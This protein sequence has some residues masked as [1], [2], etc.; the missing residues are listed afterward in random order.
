[1]RRFGRIF[2]QTP[3]PEAAKVVDLTGSNPVSRSRPY[4]FP[5]TTDPPSELCAPAV[6]ASRRQ[7]LSTR[8]LRNSSSSLAV[9]R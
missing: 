1:M 4:F 9:N 5:P 2:L 3:S 7:C 8:M 6:V